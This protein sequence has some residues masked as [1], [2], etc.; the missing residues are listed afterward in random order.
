MDFSILDTAKF[1]VSVNDPDPLQT[2]I[3][4]I[5]YSTTDWNSAPPNIINPTADLGKPYS[6]CFGH[7]KKVPL[8]YVNADYINNYYDY[9]I[10]PG[11]IESNNGNKATTVAIY[12]NKVLVNASEY[13]VYE[14]TWESL[15]PNY[16]FIRFAKEQT[17]FSGSLYEITGD[18]HG[19]K[20]G[21]DTTATRNFVRIIQYLLST[22][23]WGDWGLGLSVNTASFT[24]AAASYINNLLCDGHIS[25]QRKAQDVINELLYDCRGRLSKDSAGLWQIAIDGYIDVS[26]AAFGSKDGEYENI[27]EIQEFKKTATHDAI[28]TLTLNYGR[29][30]WEISPQKLSQ[31][32]HM[33]F[34]NA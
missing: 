18:F 1:R 27:I 4:K 15:Y 24:T 21:S 20:L 6:L 12:R 13:T 30:D 8:R 32:R 33:Y 17:D 23:T 25:E 2:L 29:N 5:V 10:G 9:I 3:P 28:K 16:A 31:T 26:A 7:C 14:G 11:E 22:S 19:L 34:L